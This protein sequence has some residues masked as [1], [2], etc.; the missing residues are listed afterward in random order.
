MYLVIFLWKSYY[1]IKGGLWLYVEC[2]GSGRL[3]PMIITGFVYARSSRTDER[4]VMPHVSLSFTYL[5]TQWC[6]CWS[7][8]TATKSESPLRATVYAVV[9][10]LIKKLNCRK[11]DVCYMCKWCPHELH[12][13]QRELP[14]CNSHAY[15][16]DKPKE[17]GMTTMSRKRERRTYRT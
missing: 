3:W 11:E 9:E 16:D 4:L 13:K 5:I 8:R 6:W 2:A 17:R 12:S 7:K 1:Y 15:L 10:M 14:N